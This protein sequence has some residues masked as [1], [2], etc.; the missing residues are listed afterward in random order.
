[1][2]EKQYTITES[3]LV[4]LANLLLGN[5]RAEQE[6]NIYN[7]G[8]TLQIDFEGWNMSFVEKE[9]MKQ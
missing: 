8:N 6:V 7:Q 1:M 3:D 9:D 2:K 5:E 4:E